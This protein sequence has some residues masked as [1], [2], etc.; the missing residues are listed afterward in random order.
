MAALG[1]A[2]GVRG[3]A[4]DP[5][6]TAALD[7]ILADS[8]LAGA[9]AGLEVRDAV[10]GEALYE[11]NVNQRLIPASNQK[12]RTSIAALEVL[13]PDHRF[14]T[15]V[16]T[17]GTNLYLRG[18]GDPTVLA[19]DLDALAADVAATGLKVVTGDLVAD[20]TWFDSVRLGTD[21]VWDDEPYSYASPISALTVAPNTDYD[22]GAVIVATG[23]GAAAGSPAAVTLTP[24][25]HY[26]KVINKATTGAAGSANT[27]TATRPH[28]TNTVVVT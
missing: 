9:S 8:R 18:G 3:A 1:P 20:D 21:W 11:R 26:V 24:P 17:S 5:A 13:G 10:T 15:D 23:P 7:Q 12:I 14:H 19:S 2:T 27:A 22:A 4:G 6:L 28:G 16:L 25:N